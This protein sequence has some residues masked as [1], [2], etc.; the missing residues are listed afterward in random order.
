MRKDSGS[1]SKCAAHVSDGILRAADGVEVNGVLELGNRVVGIEG[2]AAGKVLLG[3]SPVPLVDGLNATELGVGF[4]VLG[5][6]LDGALGGGES[7]GHELFGCADAEG[8][9]SVERG[10]VAGVGGS[11]GGIEGDGLLERLEAVREVLLVEEVA[12]A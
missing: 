6:E 3:C 9:G 10:G 1:S 4:A 8:G 2:D 5:V 7:F 12:A 11:V